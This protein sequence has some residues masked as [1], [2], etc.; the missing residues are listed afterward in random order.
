MTPFETLILATYFFILIILAGY[1]WHRYYLV[2]SYVK[3][4]DKVPVP[5]HHRR[6][7]HILTAVAAVGVLLLV[8]G[9]VELAIWPT[10]LGMSLTF[11]GKLWFVDRMVWLYEEMKDATPEYRDWGNAA[12]SFPPQAE[13]IEELVEGEKEVIP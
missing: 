3:N 7:P 11:L 12:S 5:R 6:M 13:D 8:W 2:Y 1:G 10:L 9:L 4:R